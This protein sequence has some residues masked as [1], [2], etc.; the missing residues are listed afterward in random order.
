[1]NFHCQLLNAE[2][3]GVRQTLLVAIGIEGRLL[4][5]V[6]TRYHG[7]RVAEFSWLFVQSDVRGQGIGRELLRQCEVLAQRNGCEGIACRVNAGN[8]AAVSFYRRAGYAISADYDDGEVDMFK[9]LTGVAVR[10]DKQ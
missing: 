2:I 3:M 9:N 7:K 6:Q 10:Q 5:E 8:D 1:M 4:G